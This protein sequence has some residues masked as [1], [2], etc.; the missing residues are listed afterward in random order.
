MTARSGRYWKP[1]AA[2]TKERHLPKCQG[3]A[4]RWGWKNVFLLHQVTMN[5]FSI[6]YAP[7][8]GP[9]LGKCLPL[10]AR[11]LVKLTS[12]AKKKAAPCGAAFFQI[13][14]PRLEARV[15][16]TFHSPR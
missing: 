6:P 7:S 9:A 5:C 10:N 4:G 8:S 11:P 1:V 14:N 15:T 12:D 16:H 3:L 13:S 2:G